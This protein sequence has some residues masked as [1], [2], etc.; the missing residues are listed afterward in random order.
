MYNIIKPLYE[1]VEAGVRIN[2]NLTEW[3][4]VD[5]CVRQGDN[6]APTIFAIFGIDITH[7]INSLGLG[8]E[9]LEG[10]RVSILKYA[11]DIVLIADSAE[12]LQTMLDTLY[13]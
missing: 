8:V 3:F 2:Y 13:Y 7:D 1:N 10:D 12:D 9:L 6:L 11:D 4:S 5:S